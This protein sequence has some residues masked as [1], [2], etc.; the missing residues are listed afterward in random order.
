VIA[1]A[2]SFLLAAD[3][4]PAA[5]LEAAAGRDAS[6]DPA[7]ADAYAALLAE[8]FESAA[9]H[10]RLGNARLRAGE[11]GRAVACYLRAL[12]FEPR[13]ASARAN[14]AIARAAGP[15]VTGAGRPLL[16][17]IAERTPEGVAAALLAVPWLLLWTALLARRRA[18]GGVR[19]A[20]GAGAI[21]LAFVA[22]AGAER[23]ASRWPRDR[24]P[25]GAHAPRGHRGARRRGAGRGGPGADR[26]RC[27][28][29]RAGGGHRAALSPIVTSAAAARTPSAPPARSGP[30]CARRGR[31][32]STAR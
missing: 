5:R 10:V 9:L 11:R 18:R 15:A 31:S 32:R 8:G 13:D 3:A 21:A 26:G 23:A 28:G 14:L 25:P 22:A 19:G 20:L 27:G 1:L 24:A 7:A 30:R 17:R 16:A 6:G 2:L 12:R 29:V 4:D